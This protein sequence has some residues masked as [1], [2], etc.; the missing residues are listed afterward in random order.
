MDLDRPTSQRLAT[1][2]VRP[3]R[4]GSIVKSFKLTHIKNNTVE[5]RSDNNNY[6]CL[7]P[8]YFHSNLKKII[9]RAIFQRI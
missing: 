9:Y 6:V 1:I 5:L 8:L 2:N 7:T 3:N 4:G